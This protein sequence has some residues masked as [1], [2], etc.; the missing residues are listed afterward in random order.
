MTIIDKDPQRVVEWS[1]SHGG[2]AA[3]FRAFGLEIEG[4]LIAAVIYDN[5]QESSISAHL[6]IQT[7]AIVSMNFL[8]YA[9]HYPFNELKVHKLL[10]FVDSANQKAL[11]LYARLGFVEEY[12]IPGAALGGDLVVISMTRQQCRFLGDSNGQQPKAAA[13]T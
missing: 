9:F 10:G 1:R 5:Y 6:T 4:H 12:R 8:W 2:A 3:D 11:S 13:S 7:G